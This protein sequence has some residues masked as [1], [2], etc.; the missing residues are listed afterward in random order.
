M[1]FRKNWGLFLAGFCA[2]IVNGLL[3]AGGGM[4][5]V[6]L[7][8]ALPGL[9]ENKVFPSSVAIILPICIITLIFIIPGSSYSFIAAL[10]YLFGSLVGGFISWRVGKKIPTTCLHKLLGIFILWGG[11]RYLC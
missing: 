5:L 8:T 7:L 2:G 1:F 4:I 9:P 10:P 3:G 11:I 6:P